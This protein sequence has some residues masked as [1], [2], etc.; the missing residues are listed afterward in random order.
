MIAT[1]EINGSFYKT[2]LN[3][4]I[5][6]SIPLRAGENNVNAF[7]LPPVK[8]EAFRMG[9]FVG[10]VSEGGPC[11]VNNIV[12]NPHGNGT[13]TEC[14][15]HISSEAYSI[16]QVLDNYFFSALLISITPELSNDGDFLITKEQVRKM[17]GGKKMEALIIRTKPNDDDKLIRKYSG[18]NPPYMEAAAAEYIRECGIKHLLLDLPSIDKEEDSGAL[19]AHHAFWNYPANT[20]EDC[21][22]TELIYVPDFIMDAEYLLCL[23]FPSFENDAAPSKPILYSFI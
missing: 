13:H 12:F 11:N 2:D 14:V 5:D 8:I 7:H 21:T 18:T 6:I 23:H 17:I 19:S 20:R 22:I 1:I 3:K 4:P 15:G 16:N 10:A 9:S